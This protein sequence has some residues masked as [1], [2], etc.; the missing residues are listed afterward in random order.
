[1]HRV[2]AVGETVLPPNLAHTALASFDVQLPTECRALQFQGYLAQCV[3]EEQ[4]QQQQLL[5]QCWGWTE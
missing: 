5:Q 1:M 3:V 4:Q 2:Q